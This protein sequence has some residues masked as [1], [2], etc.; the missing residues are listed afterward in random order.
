[1]ALSEKEKSAYSHYASNTGVSV[2]K[3]QAK[4]DTLKLS[5][6]FGIMFLFLL[7]T[8]ACSIGFAYLYDKV[9]R[10]SNNYTLVTVLCIVG[11]VGI[12]V[13]SI[14]AGAFISKDS[15]KQSWAS[16][17]SVIFPFFLYAISISTFF[18]LI[19]LA[20][21]I[22]VL[23]VALSSTLVA[24]GAL[25]LIGLITSDRVNIAISFVIAILLGALAIFGLMFLFSAIFG[26][27]MTNGLYWLI[28]FLFLFVFMLV[29][30]VDVARIKRIA[31][32]GYCSP[33]LT[34]YCAFELYVDFIVLF[35]RI[36][37]IVLLL[38]GRS[39]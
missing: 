12:I 27:S 34:L 39:R 36:L 33:N 2:E 24:F 16:S 5:K 32:S 11:I 10:P 25:A 18:G 6:V 13:A 23:I 22:E 9:C 28:S 4:V 15:T 29:T 26:S 1:M 14:L 38:F 37:Y 35:I 8:A 3:V 20:C 17:H 30:I 7:L 19:V 31:A 21:P